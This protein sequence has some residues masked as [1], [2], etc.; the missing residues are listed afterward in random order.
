MKRKRGPAVNSPAPRPRPDPAPRGNPYQARS[1]YPPPPRRTGPQRTHTEAPPTSNAGPSTERY[2]GTQWA[3]QPPPRREQTSAGKDAEARKNVFAAANATA[4]QN[5]NPTS[6]PHMFAQPAPQGPAQGHKY[7]VPPAF[8]A[9]QQR[10]VPPPPPP[11]QPASRHRATS[12]QE[13]ARSAFEET[14]R[15]QAN[16]TRARS[17]RTTNRPGLNPS[18]LED[19]GPV[20]GPAIYRTKSG[21]G[22]SNATSPADPPRSS[23]TTQRS[24]NEPPRPTRQKSGDDVPF[25]EGEPK[26][27]TPYPPVFEQPRN[28]YFD[29]VELNDLK[30]TTSMQDARK[31][32]AE[33]GY[34]RD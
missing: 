9:A 7:R 27:K 23:A 25:V 3:P 24:S 26:I 13:Q 15:Q 17:T 20:N 34:Q 10:P 8:Q 19:E 6:R 21:F 30:R 1:A 5:M 14:Q 16:I 28:S 18:S 32:S 12:S 31:L 33:S 2:N 29:N 22:V 11:G 4:W